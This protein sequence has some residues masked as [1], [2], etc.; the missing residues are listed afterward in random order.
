V[1][2]ILIGLVGDLL[3][4]RER[5]EEA[6]A[7]VRDLLAVPDILFGNLEANFTDDPHS[8]P[9]AGIMLFPGSHNLGAFA[10][11]GF[12]VLSMANNHSVDAGHAAML[13][14]RAQL[15]AQGVQTCGAGET[16][17]DARKPAI[18][19]KG[20][21]RVAFL[22]YASV[23]PM[24]YEAR[25]NVPGLVPLR[26]YDLYRPAFDNYHVPGTPPQI[27]TVPDERDLA[28]LAEDIAQAKRHA[29]LVFT[30][31]HWGDFLRPCHL[32]D[33]ETR[34][35]KWCIDQGADLVV[36][37]HHHALRGMEWHR[38]KPILYGLGH[39]VFDARLNISEEFKKSFA[40]LSEDAH[41]FAV[42]PREGWPLLP[43][44]PD[45]RMT[46]LAWAR[47]AAHGVTAIGFVPCLL[48]PDGCVVAVDPASNEGREVVEYVERCI[49]SQKLNA[50]ISTDEAPELAGYQ[51]LRVVPG[52]TGVIS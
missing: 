35:A 41:N 19:E 21:I 50:R 7:E 24:G 37:H 47:A 9:S 11:A 12:N 5:P 38:G 30:S 39:F 17:A 43:L 8:A 51:T 25:S 44:H 14:N 40:T 36:G 10:R 26:A 34:T 52:A 28:A 31:F 4:D 13:E 33:H 48:R 1:S 3:I 27:Q 45:T 29:D 46:L 2:D 6:L 16:L 15:R 32:T 42:F 18:L 49:T 23:F 20:G 22:A